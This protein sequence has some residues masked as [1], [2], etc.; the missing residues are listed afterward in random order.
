MFCDA[1]EPREFWV[2]AARSL[3]PGYNFSLR[4]I[5]VDVQSYGIPFTE[6]YDNDG[7]LWRGYVQQFKSGL[8]KAVPTSRTTYD[9]DM[10]FLGGVTV[11]DMQLQTTSRCE[12]PAEDAADREGWYYFTG[13]KGG[14]RPEDFEVA[15]FIRAGR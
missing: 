5:Y 3:I 8:R 2:I 11:F 6:V 12:F 1:W 9:Q 14:T 15:S 10:V 7:Q 13:D 4:I